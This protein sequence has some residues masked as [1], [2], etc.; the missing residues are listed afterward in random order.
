[1]YYYCEN[2]Y[3]IILIKELIS[4]IVAEGNVYIKRDNTYL[5]F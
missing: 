4:A 1:M 3:W 5:S 2:Y